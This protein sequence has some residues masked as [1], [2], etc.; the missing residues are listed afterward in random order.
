MDFLVV[1][2]RVLFK[3]ANTLTQANTLRQA[4]AHA[5]KDRRG[6]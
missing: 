4:T 6:R 1:A 2:D 3:K 5:M